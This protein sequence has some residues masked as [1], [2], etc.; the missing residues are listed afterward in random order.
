MAPISFSLPVSVMNGSVSK[1]IELNQNYLM[2]QF[3]SKIE[4][5]TAVEVS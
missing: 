3:H 2:E 4:R 1:Q 5:L